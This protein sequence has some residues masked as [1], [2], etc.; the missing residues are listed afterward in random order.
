[1]RI[2]FINRNMGMIRGGGE[3]FNLEIARALQELGCE[4]SFIIGSPVFG[5]IKYPVTEF[6][7]DYCR[8]PY[9]RNIAMRLIRG[10]GKLASIDAAVFE[11]AAYR[12]LSKMKDYDIIQLCGCPNLGARIAR[13]LRKKI[14]LF[15]PGPSTSERDADIRSCN[16]IISH[17]DALTQLRNRLK[18]KKEIFEILPEIN[19]E[20]FKSTETNIRRKYQINDDKLLLF[21]GRF[22]PYKNLI[23]LIRVFKETLKEHPGIR[24]M[25]V[26]EGPFEKRIKKEVKKL[27]LAKNVV[28]T[29]NIP[30]NSIAQYYWS[31]DALVLPSSYESFPLVVIEAMA[32]GLPVVAA[33]VGGI[34]LIVE[35][36]KNGFLANNNDVEGFKN[37]IIALISNKKLCGEM[38]R[39]N[40]EEVL[41]KYDWMESARKLKKIYE[42]LI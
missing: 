6:R 30:H 4:I 36:G 7:T 19:R 11:N 24:L 42:T 20:F 28:F 38:G 10:A 8:S 23:F 29:G 41:V 5:R 9:L 35:H 14:V 17:G 32:C 34:P 16:V 15:M 12:L 18:D 3:T 2:K 33:K 21:V 40:R 26:G 22:V 31:A 13:D 39:R 1:M 25:L 27:N 37:A